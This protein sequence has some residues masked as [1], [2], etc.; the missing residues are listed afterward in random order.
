MAD[1]ST[2]DTWG[3][4][5]ET[6]E[7]QPT[8]GSR[9]R[10]ERNQ[11]KEERD[12]F[13]EEVLS[14]RLEKLGLNPKEG[15]GVA[16]MDNYDGAPTAEALTT[17]LAEKYRFEVPSE[18]P[19]EQVTQPAERIAQ[20]AENGTS[21]EPEQEPDPVGVAESKMADPEAGRTEAQDAL[22][23]KMGRYRKVRSQIQ[24]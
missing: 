18:V 7:S 22:A 4:P 16:V 21:I 2:N 14:M 6:G 13:R 8:E 9:L 10:Q 12:T 15:L 3:Q 1:S 23:A 19:T 20:V 11:M 17:H 24:I 5:N